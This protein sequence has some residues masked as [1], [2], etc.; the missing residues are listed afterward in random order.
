VNGLELC[1][2][3]PRLELAAILLALE[4]AGIPRETFVFI[5]MFLSISY[6]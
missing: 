4:S 2:V 1:V 6:T 3:R 5:S